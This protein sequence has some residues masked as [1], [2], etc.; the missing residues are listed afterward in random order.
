M[1]NYDE[2]IHRLR[3]CD[4]TQYLALVREGAW[5]IQKQQDVIK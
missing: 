1:K 3:M 4:E 2:L 5:A